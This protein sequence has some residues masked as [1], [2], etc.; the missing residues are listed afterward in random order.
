MLYSIFFFFFCIAGRDTSR[1][2]LALRR[3]VVSALFRVALRS[4]VFLALLSLHGVLALHCVV[5]S[6]LLALRC[7]LSIV[8]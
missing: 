7:I 5:F 3:F 1:W 8:V 6:A 2:V 4:V